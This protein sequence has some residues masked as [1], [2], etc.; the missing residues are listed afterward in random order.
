MNASL[1]PSRRH[2]P[3]T[4]PTEL[5]RLPA[6]I[7]STA[8]QAIHCQA[9]TDAGRWTGQWGLKFACVLLAFVLARDRRTAASC[10]IAL[11]ALASQRQRTDRE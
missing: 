2:L 6:G 5:W 9:L 3:Q 10:L 4:Q 8:A 1:D 11:T 7:N